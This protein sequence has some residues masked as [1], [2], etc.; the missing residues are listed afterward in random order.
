MLTKEEISKRGKKIRQEWEKQN[1]TAVQ[2]G[3]L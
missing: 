2:T 1:R 3:L